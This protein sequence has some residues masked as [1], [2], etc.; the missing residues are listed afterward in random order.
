MQTVSVW[1][2]PKNI[3]NQRKK[4]PS[5]DPFLTT[6]TVPWAGCRHGAGRSARSGAG[7][8][9]FGR[10]KTRF[11]LKCLNEKFKR[12]RGFQGCCHGPSSKFRE[13]SANASTWFIWSLNEVLGSEGFAIGIL[14]VRGQSGVKVSAEHVHN[15]LGKHKQIALSV[16][17]ETKW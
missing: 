3:S 10:C 4:S 8:C 1:L 12:K 16:L 17:K 9:C 2:V 6:T 13:H 14:G 15:D 7:W 5:A 11:H